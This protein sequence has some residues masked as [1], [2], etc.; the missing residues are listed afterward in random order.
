MERL[1][2]LRGEYQHRIHY[3]HVTDW[4]V[5][6]PGAFPQYRYRNDLFPTSRF[7][8]AYDVLQRTHPG[9]ADREYLGLLQL[10]AQETEQGVDDAL[11]LLLAENR[12]V[13]V[14]GVRELLQSGRELPRHIEVPIPAVDLSAYDA[15]LSAGAQREATV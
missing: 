8:A 10:A 12:A 13:Q 1:P 9:M 14:S 4:L 15:L 5:R 6:K 11:R 3:R 2:R 7:R